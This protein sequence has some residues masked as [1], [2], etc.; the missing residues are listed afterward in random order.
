MNSLKHI[1]VTQTFLSLDIKDRHCQDDEEFQDCTTRYYIRKL[2]DHCGCIPL[3]LIMNDE[4]ETVC[5]SEELKCVKNITIEG[6]ECEQPCS[7][8]SLTGY[9]KSVK[10]RDFQHLIPK[11]Y[12]A[13]K[14]YKTWIAFPPAMK[15]K[16]YII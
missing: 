10:N 2:K 4:T 1:K 9:F 7:G 3:N 16:R 12:E 8:L 15:G 5:N 11:T 14:E 6:H 13:Y